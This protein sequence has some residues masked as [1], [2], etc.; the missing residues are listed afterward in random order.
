MRMEYDG[1]TA[2]CTRRRRRNGGLQRLT[3]LLLCAPHYGEE[4]RAPVDLRGVLPPV[5]AD[6]PRGRISPRETIIWD[7]KV[8]QLR[9][10]SLRLTVGI[11]CTLLGTFMLVAPHR[12]TGQP[13]T[14]V[15]PGVPVWSTILLLAGLAVLS[16][17]FLPA[18]KAVTTCAHLFAAGVL[19]ALASAFAVRGMWTAVSVCG[20]LALGLIAVAALLLNRDRRPSPEAPHLLSLVVGISTTIT[21]LVMLALPHE[22]RAPAYDLLR[23]HLPWFGAAFLLSG[24]PLVY[25]TLR[26]SLPPRARAAPHLLAAG[27]FFAFL[28]AGPAPAGLWPGVIYYSVTGSVLAVLAWSWA[29]PWRPDPYS[30]K[31]RLA[32]VTATV[33]ALSI[34]TTV[35]VVNT[36]Q[37]SSDKA[38]VREN[39]ARTAETLAHAVS[40]YIRHHGSLATLLASAGPLTSLPPD[41]QVRVLTTIN[42]LYPEVAS[43]AIQD[44]FGNGVA[45]SD[46][47]PL[48]SMAGFPVFEQARSTGRL[49]L[50]AILSPVIQRPVFRVG[51]PFYDADGQFAGVVVAVVDTRY[52]AELLARQTES[53][54]GAAYLVDHQGRAIV[55]PP[56]SDSDL[57]ELASA[58]PVAE[59]LTSGSNSGTLEYTGRGQ[60]QLAAYARVPDFG[61]AVVVETSESE[62]LAP[63]RTGRDLAT[64]L[65]VVA[66]AVAAAVANAAARAVASPIKALALA[67]DRLASGDSSVPLPKSSISE[68]SSLVCNFQKMRSQLMARTDEVERA[69]AQLKQIL[70]STPDALLITDR[71]G[72]ITMV[73]GQAERLF[74]YRADQMVGQPVELLVPEESRHI[75]AAL[76]QDYMA[77][78]R[79]RAMGSGLDIWCLRSDGSRFP[80]DVSLSPLRLG[81]ETQVICLVRD[82]TDRK[83]MEEQLLQAQRL[84]MAGRV[85]SQVAHDFNNLLSPLLGYPELVKM[86]LPKDHPAASYCDAMLGA[87]RQMAQ[88]NEDLLTLGRRARAHGEPT[89]VNAVVQQALAQMEATPP[90]LRVEVQ[91]AEDLLLAIASPAQLTRVITN[92]VM[93]ARDAMRDSG[94]LSIST[95]NVYVDEPSGWHRRVGA[96]QYVRLDVT[97]TGH[98]IPPEIRDM[99]FEPFFTT[100]TADRR[101]GS[102]LGLSIVHAIVSD[103][104]GYVDFHSEVGKG[105][106]F[107]IYL[108]VSQPEGRKEGAEQSGEP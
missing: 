95:R 54:A 76:R 3:G 51:A 64:G 73:N 62:A 2:H 13:Y 55:P 67:V 35:T 81:A 79:V 8:R 56:W 28:L 15:E 10:S 38:L 19:L 87:A 107:S 14:L 90:T 18:P 20:T 23:P 106:T 96:G 37:E 91:L 99:I 70:E 30:I 82:I 44:R 40:D 33:A 68:V 11:C 58:P 53:K 25:V 16:T 46:G 21:G 102:G 22:F 60:T 104:G 88:I 57:A 101:R 34:V 75:H 45:R 43:F 92:L 98:G 49:G 26:P 72:R 69:H 85:A 24:L 71:L 39:Q 52:M 4:P 48:I 47:R 80:A 6:L 41:A 105:T 32:V 89:D 86:E 9:T 1:P 100:K 5:A 31:T 29:R 94:V 84:E 74:G 103:Y 59:M 77:A 27:A 108:P 97:D 7:V 17:G 83:R 42:A 65:L 66:I 93:N 61:W 78:P 63:F 50:D 12:F 36:Y